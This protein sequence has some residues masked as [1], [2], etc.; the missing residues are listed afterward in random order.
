MQI[1]ALE[2]RLLEIGPRPIGRK[3]STWGVSSFPTMVGFPIQL[4]G[5]SATS[6]LKTQ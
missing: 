3:L 2:I 5:A 4:Q 1:L 6:Q